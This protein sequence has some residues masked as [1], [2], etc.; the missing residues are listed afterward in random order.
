MSIEDV[1]DLEELQAVEAFRQALLLDELLP[2]RHDD[3]HMMLRY[4]YP[5]NYDAPFV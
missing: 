1:R 5:V 2:A 3:Y 4:M